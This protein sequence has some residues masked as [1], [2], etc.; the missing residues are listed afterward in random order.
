MYLWSV[1]TLLVLFVTHLSLSLQHRPIFSF[2]TP[3]LL[4]A[5]ATLLK[6]KNRPLS[7]TTTTGLRGLPALAGRHVHRCVSRYF[8]PLD[9][10]LRAF[11]GNDLC[12]PS[13]PLLCG[14]WPCWKRPVVLSLV[15]RSGGMYSSQLILIKIIIRQNIFDDLPDRRK[16]SEK[17]HFFTKIYLILFGGFKYFL[18]LCNVIN[19]GLQRETET[20]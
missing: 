13:T 1:F 4:A 15:G 8:Q 17:I 14:T 18:Y 2:L 19:E 16:K 10:R 5:S 12:Q 9:I 7:E 3:I 11:A 6:T 20:L